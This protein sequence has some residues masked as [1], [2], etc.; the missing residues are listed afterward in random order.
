VSRSCQVCRNPMRERIDRALAS[1]QSTRQLS[2]A[3]KGV[4]RKQL[5]RHRERCLIRNP[6]LVHALKA[7]DLTYERFD[8]LLREK[9]GKSPEEAGEIVEAVRE[10]LE[11]AI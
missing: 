1:G 8:E 7:G 3:F 9:A 5:A 10:H 2:H 11:K 6:F 4:T